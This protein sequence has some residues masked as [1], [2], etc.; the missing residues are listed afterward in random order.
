MNTFINYFVLFIL[1]CFI[2]LTLIKMVFASKQRKLSKRFEEEIGE[3]MKELAE[4]IRR[5]GGDLQETMGM[6]NQEYRE[7]FKELPGDL[8]REGEKAAEEIAKE[9]SKNPTP[10]DAK[11]EKPKPG[12]KT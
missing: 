9:Q 10:K 11:K 1:G 12:K 7:L 5:K 6:I 3:Q 8:K 2:V 4:N